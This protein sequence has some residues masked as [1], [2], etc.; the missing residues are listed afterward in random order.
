MGQK[1]LYISFYTT[2][3]AMETEELMRISSIIGK[4]VPVP[5]NISA[6]CGL[7]WQGNVEDKEKILAKLHEKDI[8]YEEIAEI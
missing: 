8:E 5:R 6:T 2:R 7:A 3:E 1:F 4:L